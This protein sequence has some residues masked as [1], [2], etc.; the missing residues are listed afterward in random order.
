MSHINS[1]QIIYAQNSSHIK[2]GSS[3][4]AFA[5]KRFNVINLCC[6][7]NIILTSSQVTGSGAL[8]EDKPS[9]C[10]LHHVNFMMIEAAI[11]MTANLF[12]RCAC[13]DLYSHLSK[14]VLFSMLNT[15]QNMLFKRI[16][17]ILFQKIFHWFSV[18][19]LWCGS[20]L[21]SL[22]EL[23]ISAMQYLTPASEMF[24]TLM[25]SRYNQHQWSW[26]AKCT[27]CTCTAWQMWLHY[28]ALF[29]SISITE[30]ERTALWDRI[31][32]VDYC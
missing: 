26:L 6:C 29:C 27:Q 15:N 17:L 25:L 16:H 2:P 32:D 13:D 7:G 20:P 5:N 23:V 3:G 12:G 11:K 24:S 14:H 28:L 22:K 8:C 30:Y 21:Q 9:A 4:K 19:Q 18:L 1:K 31:T 10:A